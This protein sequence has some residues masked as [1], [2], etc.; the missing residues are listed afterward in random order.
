MDHGWEEHLQEL[1]PEIVSQQQRLRDVVASAMA[2]L[3]AGLDPGAQVS[4]LVEGEIHPFLQ[5][6]VGRD[7]LVDPLAAA[8]DVASSGRTVEEVTGLLAA[9]Q[10]EGLLPPLGR[11]VDEVNALRLLPYVSTLQACILLWD[12][13]TPAEHAEL[14]RTSLRVE[15]P[16][17]LFYSFA[18]AEGTSLEDAVRAGLVLLAW[19][20]ALALG[21]FDLGAFDFGSLGEGAS[22]L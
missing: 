11:G 4:A 3:R 1:K 2:S 21:S 22:D 7:F 8:W 6:E 12:G 18:E 19:L 14:V 16:E 5:V 9:G 13:C 10:S 15:P 20:E 17:E